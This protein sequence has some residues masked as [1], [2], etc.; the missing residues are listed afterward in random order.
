MNNTLIMI[1]RVNHIINT[2]VALLYAPIYTI[3]VECLFPRK[4]QFVTNYDDYQNITGA[5][6]VYDRHIQ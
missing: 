2:V 3:Q 4:T 5:D 6:C 1:T